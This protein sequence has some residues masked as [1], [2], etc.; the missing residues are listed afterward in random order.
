[1]AATESTE[2]TPSGVREIVLYYGAQALAFAICE[3]KLRL[4]RRR[5]DGVCD[6]CDESTGQ[7]AMDKLSSPI[8]STE[9]DATTS[10]EKLRAML[11]AEYFR[12]CLECA[13]EMEASDAEH[14]GAAD[15]E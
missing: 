9:P 11:D 2:Y 5:H 10:R 15:G 12:F 13:T 3:P 7:Y 6:R 8:D 1:M 4:G 14:G